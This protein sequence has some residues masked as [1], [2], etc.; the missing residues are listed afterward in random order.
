VQ[1]TKNWNQQQIYFGSLGF[2]S[3]S[4]FETLI[5]SYFSKNRN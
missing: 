4:A 5:C 3:G 2:L 1:N